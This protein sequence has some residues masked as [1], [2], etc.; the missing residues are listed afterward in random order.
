MMDV[1]CDLN[2]RKIYGRF[3]ELIRAESAVGLSFWGFW[4]GALLFSE[5]IWGGGSSKKDNFDRSQ[6]ITNIFFDYDI[7]FNRL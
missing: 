6:L 3:F 7:F 5:V 1:W 4:R 2:A